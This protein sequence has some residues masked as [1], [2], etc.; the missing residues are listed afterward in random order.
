M[1]TDRGAAAA[2]AA[3]PVDLPR[4]ARRPRD[5]RSSSTGG[6]A[7]SAWRPDGTIMAGN[8][9]GGAYALTPAG[10]A[11]LGLPDAELRLDDA[12]VR[13]RRHVLLGLA[14]L[15]RVRAGPRRARALEPARPRGYFVASPA[16]GAD[17]DAST[18]PRST[19]AST[20]STR[21][22]ARCAGRSRT[23]DHVYASPALGRRPARRSTSRSTDGSVYALGPG[24]PPALAL[25]HGRRRAL[26]A[27][28]RA[29]A[30][31]RGEV[32]YVG[33]SDGV[34]YA[35]DAAT[36]RRRWSFDTT[37]RRAG[38]AR[39]QRPQRLARRW[40]AAAS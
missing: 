2:L 40:A 3:H 5:G 38:A 9:G 12:G 18:R 39:P 29:R 20:R 34:L 16:I 17:G 30:G 21:R 36:G 37:P 7:T 32:V 33:S 23:G 22:P 26:V 11:A 27:G 25:R 15:P 28:R 35:L 19:A 13:P 14:G 10:R 8:T 6:R 4:R 24:R 31:G 1:R